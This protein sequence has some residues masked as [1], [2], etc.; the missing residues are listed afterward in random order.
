[1]QIPTSPRHGPLDPEAGLGPALVAQLPG[2]QR[3]RD[4]VDDDEL[5][6][7]HDHAG[8]V[9]RHGV[10]DGLAPLA[11]AQGREHAAR[12]LG[13]PDGASVEGYAEVG[14]CFPSLLSPLFLSLLSSAPFSSPFSFL[15]PLV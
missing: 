11:Q 9:G 6:D 7:L 12:A 10:E 8:R 4:L 3:R 1:M 13:E 5:L 2:G 15:S 14:H